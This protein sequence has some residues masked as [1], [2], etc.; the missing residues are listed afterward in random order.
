[1]AKNRIYKFE[2]I[3]LMELFLNGALFGGPLQSAQGGGTPS[4]IGAGVN[5]LVGLTLIF[6]TPNVTVTFVTSD[7][8]GG[9]AQPGVGTNP[10]KYT[11][12]FKDIKMQ[13]EAASAALKVLY[14]KRLVIVEAAPS[15]GLV[16]SG[17][18]TANALLGLGKDTVTTLVYPPIS[19]TVAA[20]TPPCWTW[21]YSVN[22]N[23]HVV[24]TLEA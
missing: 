12:L 9:S 23:T 7:G 19:A 24:F 13:I 15:G 6:T 21:A 17:T 22:E 2:S 18:G 4:N 10:D 14:D 11:L 5:G 20:G 1:M 16:M 8:V 3:D